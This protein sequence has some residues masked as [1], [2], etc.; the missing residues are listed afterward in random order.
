MKK[1]VLLSIFFCGIAF[2]QAQTK[3]ELKTEKAEK[4][5]EANAI[6]SKID[7]LPG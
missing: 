7:A 2:T 1:I 5:A 6:Q 4:Q 3:D